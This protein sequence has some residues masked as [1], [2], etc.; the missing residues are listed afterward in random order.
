M[1]TKIYDAYE[2]TGR[3]GIDA[4][5]SHLR[6]MRALIWEE[7]VTHVGKHS[8]ADEPYYKLGERIQAEMRSGERSWL[9]C[10]TSAVVYPYRG[11]LFVQ[12]FGLDDRM[13]FEDGTKFIDKTRFKDMSYWNNTD[14]EDGVSDEDWEA[15]G[16]LWDDILGDDAVPS[17][18]GLSYDFVGSGDYFRLS[19]AL[20][21]RRAKAKVPK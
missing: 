13:V 18:A 15:R 20:N 1:S 8:P 19:W 21:T 5:M 16:K 2:Y 9:N 6:E 4:L 12:F 7:V 10:Q 17:I 3:G 11:R 14:P